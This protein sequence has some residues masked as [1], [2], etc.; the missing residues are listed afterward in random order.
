MADDRIVG[1]SGCPC[2]TTLNLQAGID[3]QARLRPEV[4][5]GLPAGEVELD[6][7]SR[8][9]RSSTDAGMPVA[10]NDKLDALPSTP[11]TPWVTPSNVCSHQTIPNSISFVIAAL[12]DRRQ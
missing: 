1:R 3:E 5:T 4:A 8:P 9:A 10:S 6:L 7:P 2:M 12:P 11:G